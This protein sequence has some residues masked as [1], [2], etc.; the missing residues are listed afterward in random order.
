MSAVALSASDLTANVLELI[1]NHRLSSAVAAAAAAAATGNSTSGNGT[2]AAAAAKSRPK[3]SAA[4]A[5]T[6]IAADF[7]H[8][9]DQILADNHKT[10]AAGTSVTVS[11]EKMNQLV[12]AAMKSHKSY[13]H[14]VYYLESFIKNVNRHRY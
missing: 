9:L 1:N 5:A 2:T 10:A 11:K 4:A 6:T 7:K 3:D 14:V 13:K 8:L 12:R